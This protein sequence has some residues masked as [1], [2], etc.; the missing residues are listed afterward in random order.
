MPIEIDYNN[1]AIVVK[2]SDEVKF[3][4]GFKDFVS[5]EDFKPV[6]ELRSQLREI[7]LGKKDAEQKDV[8]KIE[9]E[10]WDKSTSISLEDAPTYKQAIKQFS[11]SEISRII[12][13]IFSFLVNWSAK[14]EVLLFGKS[15]AINEAKKKNR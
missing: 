10:L 11:S 3:T 2:R 7:A 13:E 8:D 14:E 5:A 12:E 9:K 15:L 1:A 6:N 4:Y